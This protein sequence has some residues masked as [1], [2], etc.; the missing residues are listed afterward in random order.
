MCWPSFR[1]TLRACLENTLPEPADILD[2][3]DLNRHCPPL[4]HHRTV[5][6]HRGERPE[7]E[8][9]LGIQPL[10]VKGDRTIALGASSP[11]KEMK[12]VQGL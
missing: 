3:Q 6:R 2:S 5:E 12:Q 9:Q 11:P 7:E 8:N 10:V 1:L 4:S